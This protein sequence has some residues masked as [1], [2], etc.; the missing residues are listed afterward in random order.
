MRPDGLGAEVPQVDAACRALDWRS[1]RSGGGLGSAEPG[2]DLL[3]D[4]VEA[5]EAV[6]ALAEGEVGDDDLVEADR[7]PLGDGLGDVVG[8]AGDRGAGGVLA[9]GLGLGVVVGDEERAPGR[10]A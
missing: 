5:V 9:E 7:L 3:D 8:R 1:V 2:G 10:S 4:E 6:L